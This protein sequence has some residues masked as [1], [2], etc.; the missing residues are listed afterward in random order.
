MIVQCP[1]PLKRLFASVGGVSEV[2]ARGDPLPRHDAWLP[3]LSLAGTLGV[4]GTNI[5]ADAGDRLDKPGKAEQRRAQGAAA[6]GGDGERQAERHADAD[7][8]AAQQQMR[9]DQL[10]QLGQ[11]LGERGAHKAASRSAWRRGTSIIALHVGVVAPASKRGGRGVGADA[12][13]DQHDDPVG[14][15]QAP[16]RRRG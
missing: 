15:Q 3:L 8:A 7:R 2:V 11:S 16:R 1:A 10:R 4:H 13:V 5:P 9:A 12:A 6:R 14:E